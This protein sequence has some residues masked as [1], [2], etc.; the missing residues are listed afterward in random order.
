MQ[1]S[2]GLHHAPGR[3]CEDPAVAPRTRRA[4]GGEGAQGFNEG[5]SGV[6]LRLKRLFTGFSTGLKRVFLA[7]FCKARGVYLSLLGS[8]ESFPGALLELLLWP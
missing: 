6:C 5:V 3:L 7:D 2:R 8:M 1:R 4:G